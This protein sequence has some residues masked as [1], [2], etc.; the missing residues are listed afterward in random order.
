MSSILL[1]SL[2]RHLKIILFPVERPGDFLLRRY[3][4]AFFFFFFLLKNV[5]I[6]VIFRPIFKRFSL[7]YAG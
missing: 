5:N 1:H 2:G 7:L 6:S 4:A 3:P